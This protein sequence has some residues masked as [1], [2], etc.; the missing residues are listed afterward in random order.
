MRGVLFAD[1]E[2]AWIS[3]SAD[4]YSSLLRVYGILKR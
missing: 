4:K 3:E 1:G 2:L